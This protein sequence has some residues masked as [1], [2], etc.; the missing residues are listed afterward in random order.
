MAEQTTEQR[1]QQIEKVFNRAV[2]TCMS[3]LEQARIEAKINT[4]PSQIVESQQAFISRLQKLQDMIADGA[5]N[6]LGEF[7]WDFL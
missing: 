6:P 2:N 5:K 1:T 7:N 3:V 4:L